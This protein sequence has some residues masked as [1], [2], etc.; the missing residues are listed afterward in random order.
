MAKLS[1]VLTASND[2][3]YVDKAIRSILDQTFTDLEVLVIDDGSTDGTGQV[4]QAI[5]DPRL[6][7]HYLPKRGMAA[8]RNEGIQ[9]AR[10]EWVG[11]MNGRDWA[12]PQRFEKQLEFVA[13]FGADFV[14]CLPNLVDEAGNPLADHHFS[15]FYS[16][17]PLTASEYLLAFF[18]GSNS[19]YG[20]SLLARTECLRTLGP[21]RHGFVELHEMEMWV[22]AVKRFRV[23]G[24]ND[25]LMTHRLG[26]PNAPGPNRF[27]KGTVEAQLLFEHIFD[28]AAHE[29]LMK[30]F[31][32][33][34]SPLGKD[35]PEVL[36]VDKA[37]TYLT[38][39]DRYVRFVGLKK[40]SELMESPRT[41][42]VLWEHRSFGES[43]L[44]R[45]L[46]AFASPGNPDRPI[47][48]E[49]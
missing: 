26:D 21:F 14:F 24:I 18:F 23:R 12:E 41:R 3:A 37:F 31:K 20:S 43:Q 15:N 36:E 46:E 25:R 16:G 4:V 48:L 42:S 27:T 40:L 1:V 6:K 10:G 35:V 2:S 30:A 13:T 5:S 11:L 38:H 19:L 9:L 22:R 44:H 33:T 17:F 7:Y 49:A 39:R 8:A 28:D 34:I 45:L 32:E 29:I 47:S